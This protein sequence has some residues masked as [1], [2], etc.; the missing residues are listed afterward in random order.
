MQLGIGTYSFPWAI[1]VNNFKPPCPLT[2]VDL[3]NYAA[4]KNIRFV[5]FGD[6]YPLHQFAKEE[7]ANLKKE[8]DE[9]GIQ[10]EVGTRRLSI[11]NISTYLAIANL[12]KASFLRMV[13]DDADYHPDEQDVI[14]IIKKSLA[15]LQ[16]SNVKLAIEN[17]DRFSSVVLKRIIEDTDPQ[18]V[19]ICL[20]TANSLG[21]GEG[22]GEVAAQLAPYTINL[23]IKD[24]TIERVPHKMGFQ[25]RGCPA[26]TGMLNIP[27]LVKE[28]TSRSQCCTATLEV[29]SDVE[30]TIEATV[31][32]EQQWVE[33]SI[34]YLKTII[35]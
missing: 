13:I 16:A 32:K 6:N 24:F 27:W 33:Q 23:H 28:V 20:D 26:G 14:G 29:W 4:R 10:I 31:Q 2:A 1:G 3:L 30:A 19:G 17:H 7:V 34:D 21:A 35:P 22:I 12:M 11:E 25:V 18:W 5:Q 15:Q 8:A 9:S